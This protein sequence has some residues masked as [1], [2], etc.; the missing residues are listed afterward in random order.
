MATACIYSDNIYIPPEY[1]LQMNKNK[2]IKWVI[3]NVMNINLHDNI[4]PMYT[5]MNKEV[6][7]SPR[8]IIYLIFI[9]FSVKTNNTHKRVREMERDG[10]WKKEQ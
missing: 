4:I 3:L 9:L 8:S 5:Y 7:C 1:Y 2:I 6:H 10:S